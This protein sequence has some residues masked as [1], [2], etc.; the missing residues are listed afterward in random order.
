MPARSREE[1]IRYH[2]QFYRSHDLFEEGSWLQTPS[3]VV[4]GVLRHLPDC[5]PLHVLDLGA[6]VGRN[7]IALA[8]LVGAGRVR[9]DCVDM[10]PSAIRRLR[11]NAERFGVAE[12]VAAEVQEVEFYR[13]RPRYYHLVL[14]H[15]CLEHLPDRETLAE[16]I[17]RMQAGTRPGGIHTITINTGVREVDPQGRE[18]PALIETNLSPIEGETLLRES[19]SRWQVLQLS[20]EDFKETLPREGQVLEWKSDLLSFAAIRAPGG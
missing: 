1:T 3:P 12:S 2:R 7:A 11:E 17:K 19:Y 9:I 14:A 4:E 16:V 20:H 15:S 5:T 18:Q 13:I 8:R 6:G 10:L